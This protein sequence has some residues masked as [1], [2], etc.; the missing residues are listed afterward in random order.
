MSTSAACDLDVRVLLEPPRALLGLRLAREPLHRRA[1]KLASV[2]GSLKAPVAYCMLMLANPRPGHTLA[3]LL[4]G[5]GTILLEA[6]T[7]WDPGQLVGSDHDPAAI[8]AA[9]ANAQNARASAEWL[10]AD[11]AALPCSDGAL[12]AVCSNLPWGRQVQLADS[13][14]FHTALAAELVRTLTP[15]GR[16]VL[17][18]DQIES[19]L[20]ACAAQ[21]SLQLALAQ[22]ISLYGSHPSICVFIKQRRPL[23]PLRPFARWHDEDQ[24]MGEVVRSALLGCL[25]HP[26]APLRLRAL[27]ACARSSER[28]LLEAAA[29][30]AQDRDAHIRDLAAAARERLARSEQG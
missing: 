19:L 22:P 10:L 24:A 2:P 23:G 25:A 18:T 1:Y 6:E 21:G 14:A 26:Y 17:L 15:F 9:C 5:A 30:F 28:T 12:A 8:A 4:C 7:N 3:D 16:A 27:R 20:E 29:A 13:P 11:A